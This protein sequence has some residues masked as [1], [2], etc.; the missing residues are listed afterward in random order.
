M[1]L[2]LTLTAMGANAEDDNV[3]KGKGEFRL[4]FGYDF[5]LQKGS[6]GTILVTPEY[7]WKLTDNVYFGIGTG[8]MADDGFNNI[9]IPIFADAEY[10]FASS[11]GST[12]YISLKGGYNISTGDMDGNVTI[13]PNLGIKVPIGKTTDLNLSVGYT[14]TIVDG[15]GSDALGAKIGFIFNSGGKG[16]GTA[17]HHFF[18]STDWTLELETNT[19]VESK[20]VEE[21]TDRYGTAYTNTYTTKY[22]SIYGLRFSALRKIAKNFYLGISAGGGIMTITDEYK[23]T[24]NDGYDY[25][26]DGTCLYYDCYLRLKYKF[27]QL[28]IAKKLYPFIM[29]DAGVESNE[30]TESGFSAIP[31]IGLSYMTGDKSS[32]DLSVG[33]KDVE[34]DSH[35]SDAPYVQLK[36]CFRIALGYTF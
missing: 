13:N 14:R 2:A 21:K 22:S 33:Y 32:I 4:N 19:A 10:N 26:Y 15:G 36:H 1:I 16:L 20:C 29:V 9:W 34:P 17:L 27:K 24:G 11:G 25:V 28:T 3:E 23:S 31:A 18:S 35:E 8:M 6:S 12:P 5:G 30:M 7:A